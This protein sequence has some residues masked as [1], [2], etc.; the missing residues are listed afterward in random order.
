MTAGLYFDSSSP[1]PRRRAGSGKRVCAS[2]ESCDAY[3]RDQTPPFG[4]VALLVGIIFLTAF[5]FLT[6]P[7]AHAQ[8]GYY[9]ASEKP[10]AA[11]SGS[12]DA[13]ETAPTAHNFVVTS[14]EKCYAQLGHAEAMDIEQ[15]FVKPYQECQRRLA[16]KI[17]QQHEVKPGQQK[18]VTP[19]NGSSQNS[20]MQSPPDNP[21]SAPAPLT[22]EGLYYRVQKNTL[23]PPPSEDDKP[24]PAPDDKNTQSQPNN[25][26][27]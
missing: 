5:C 24:A 9:N 26:S 20:T 12:S 6:A 10:A 25:Q 3:R 27:H 2:H 22:D 1:P 16:L 21:A 23:P 19:Q 11:D 17:K 7:P 14:I 15:H 18:T 8:T 4:G 13:K